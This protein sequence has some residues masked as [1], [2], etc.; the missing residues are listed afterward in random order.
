MSINLSFWLLV[1]WFS[2]PCYVKAVILKDL[3]SLPNQD[4]RLRGLNNNFDVDGI[5]EGEVK[6]AR[7]GGHTMAWPSDCICTDRTLNGHIDAAS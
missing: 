1:R 4:F 6:G 3:A 5:L 2:C 7:E